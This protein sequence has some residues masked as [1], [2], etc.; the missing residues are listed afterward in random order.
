[1]IIPAQPRVRSCDTVVVAAEATANGRTLFGKNS[2]RHPNEAQYLTVVPAAD[3]APGA[4]V[5]CTFV[6]VPQV[7]HTARVV[8]S[9]PW[10]MWGFE[11]GVNEY[12]VAIGNEA[13]WSKL[14]ARYEAGLLG[15]DLLR[16]TLE[17]STTADEALD[18]L[19]ALI[20][21]HG[22][23]GPTNTVVLESYD[24]GFVIADPSTAWLVQT[25]GK[26]WA[27][28]RVDGAAAMSNL[29]TI[30]TD[31][32]RLA[33]GAVEEAIARGWF[34]PNA[35]EPFDFAR[36]FGDEN[37]PD[38]DGCARRFDRS[39]FLLHELERSDR[40]IELRDIHRV[41]RDPGDGPVESLR[42]GPRSEGAICMYA[43]DAA[44]SET[45]ATIIAELDAEPARARIGVSASAPRHAGLV[46]IWVDLDD[47]GA[48]AQPEDETDAD[49]WWETERLQRRIE[50]VFPALAPIADAV[51]E[52]V[53]R[54]FFSQSEQLRAGSP[55][56]RHAAS[57]TGVAR[58]RAAVAQ[59][60]ELF[61]ALVPVLVEPGDEDLRGD[62]L[63]RLEELA[64]ATTS[65]RSSLVR[66]RVLADAQRSMPA[67]A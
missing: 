19:L 28:K 27:A 57:I 5:E 67:S 7:S 63:E 6:S 62:H 22:Q 58:H 11:H 17:R 51:F 44:G 36:A 38:L 8:G 59:L 18:C 23:S 12:G 60:E 65:R 41:L 45:A 21:A 32:T 4:T 39:S 9:R 16:L 55:E 46:P 37:L 48:F 49:L 35:G 1:M 66:K 61:D 42:P 50:A 10:W 15:M 64:E 29:Y 31:Y 47:C 33:N 20:E 2:D 14:P 53:N 13:L 34:D 40:P 52:R 24:N 26:Y 54:R 25:A 43:Q 30:G 56:E 3:H